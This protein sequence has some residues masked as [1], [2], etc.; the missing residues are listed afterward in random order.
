[1]IESIK[2]KMKGDGSIWTIMIIL[3]LISVLS[4]YSSIQDLAFHRYHG[5]TIQLFVKHIIILILGLM[6]CW[7]CHKIPYMNYY[8][9]APFLLALIIPMLALTLLIGATT[10]DATRRINLPFFN[11]GLQTS[12]YAKLFIIIYLARVLSIKQD[13]I[14]NSIKVFLSVFWPIPVICILIAPEN[15]STSLLVFAISFIMLYL[16][17]AKL[18]H[19]FYLVALGL[20]SFG[21]VWVI[22][23][24][25]PNSTRMTTWIFRIKEFLFNSDGGY[26]VQQAKIAIAQGGVFGIGLGHSV[27]KNF[28]PSPYA[29][30]IYSIIMEEMGLLISGIILLMYIFFL[31][32]CIRIIKI[33]Q[34][35]FASLLAIG[36]SVNLVFQALVNMGVSVNL[37]P[38]TGLPLPLISRGGNA[39]IVFCISVGII[40]SVSR[41]VE[42]ELREQRLS[43]NETPATT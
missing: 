11:I 39:I 1:M 14:K 3:M 4:V 38:V 40:L 17:R 23:L 6:F 34:K 13:V 36:L 15:L 32:R 29:D 25:Y 22:D 8:K 26:Q 28:L 7:I 31:I 33:S 37:L 19:L 9:Y 43:N 41:S 10:N 21:L 18:S 16:G 12:E 42:K 30:F 2:L 20:V 24:I 5:E 35:S 27:Q